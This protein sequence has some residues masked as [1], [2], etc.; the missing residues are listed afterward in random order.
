MTTGCPDPAELVRV[1][2]ATPAVTTAATVSPA[3]P[4]VNQLV[5][6]TDTATLVGAVNPDGTGTVTFWLVG[7]ATG[8]P[9][10]CPSTDAAV[11][12]PITAPI[13]PN[14]TAT[15]GPVT[16]TPTQPGDYYWVAAFGGDTNNNATSPTGCADPAELVHVRATPR[17]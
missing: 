15:T 12:G 10:A 16:F 4:V 6:T 9:P 13:A 11:L 8:D 1:G 5:T 14:G 2:K 7:P 3:D 17:W